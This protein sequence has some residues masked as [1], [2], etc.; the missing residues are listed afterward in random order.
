MSYELPEIKMA[1]AVRCSAW[2]PIPRHFAVPACR[3]LG[4][5]HTHARYTLDGP[6]AMPALP[7]VSRPLAEARPGGSTGT[8]SVFGPFVW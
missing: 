7:L 3:E 4:V 6:A 2:F 1:P 5:G 8:R